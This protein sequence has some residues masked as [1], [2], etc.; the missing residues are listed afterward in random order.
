MCCLCACDFLLEDEIGLLLL[1]Q[2]GYETRLITS[3]VRHHISPI[4]CCS[5]VGHTSCSVM[6]IS[7]NSCFSCSAVLGDVVRNDSFVSSFNGHL[8][9]EVEDWIALRS[10]TINVNPAFISW[11]KWVF[12]F[13]L[14]CIICLYV[15]AQGAEARLF[16]QNKPAGDWAPRLDGW[17]QLQEMFG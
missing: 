8:Q 5:G 15:M 3:V 4:R 11:C 12:G 10:R 16:L 6:D 1:I 13:V 2:F 17:R 14:C 9:L 7:Q